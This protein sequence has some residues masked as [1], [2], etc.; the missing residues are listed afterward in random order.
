M[1]EVTIPFPREETT[2]PVTKIYLGTENYGARGQRGASSVVWAGL[3]SG[4]V[5]CLPVVPGR[6]QGCAT[7]FKSLA[8][9]AL[10]DYFCP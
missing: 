3:C 5:L 9:K 7:T 4:V 1:E 10:R 6:N 2:P 8:D